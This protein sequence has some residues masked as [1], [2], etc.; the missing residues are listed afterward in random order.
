MKF[1]QPFFSCYFTLSTHVPYDIP[2]YFP[3]DWGGSENL[4]LNSAAY[5][6]RQ[7]GRFFEEIE[8]TTI[9]D[10]TVFIFVSDHGHHTPANHDYDSPEHHHI[11]LLI[12][13]GALKEEFGGVKNDILGSKLDVASTL[14]HQLEIKCDDF[15]WSKNLMNPYTSPFAF[16]IFNDGVG[17]LEPG[18]IL[19]WNRKFATHKKNNGTT[20]QEQDSLQKKGTALLQELMND[21]LKR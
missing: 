21:F 13:G 19:I 4:Y 17:Y 1:Q 12:Y 10:S 14:L 20:M 15:V 6:D 18:K 9:Y 7:L 3:I 11:P 16:Y 5:A 8:K 2:T